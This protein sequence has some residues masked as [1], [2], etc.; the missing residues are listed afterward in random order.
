MLLC[1]DDGGDDGEGRRK[2]YVGDPQRPVAEVGFGGDG[3]GAIIKHLSRL[4]RADLANDCTG[5]WLVG[6]PSSRHQG[7][8]GCG[9]ASPGNKRGRRL[10]RCELGWNIGWVFLFF[11]TPHDTPRVAGQQW[12]FGLSIM[13]IPILIIINHHQEDSS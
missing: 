12:P 2:K 8:P 10:G 9:P 13:I 3:G 4:G 7:Q 1:P 6:P 5:W 11:Q